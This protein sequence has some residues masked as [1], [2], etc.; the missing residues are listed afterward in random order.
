MISGGH[1]CREGINSGQYMTSRTEGVL[2]CFYFH[3]IYTKVII[4]CDA[5]RIGRWLEE[6]WNG[7]LEELVNELSGHVIKQLIWC[8]MDHKF[9]VSTNGRVCM[10]F[11]KQH[12]TAQI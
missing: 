11:S 1:P 3:E 12:S 8:L 6:R 2:V 5:S 10:I 7:P 4:E 9:E